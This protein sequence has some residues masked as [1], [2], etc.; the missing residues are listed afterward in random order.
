MV[1]LVIHQN[2]IDTFKFESQTPIF[3]DPYCPMVLQVAFQRMKSPVGQVHLGRFLS[4]VQFCQ[5]KAQSH[6][7]LGLYA[8]L[9]ASVEKLLQPFVAE[10]FYHFL[11]IALLYEE[12]AMTFLKFFLSYTLVHYAQTRWHRHKVDASLFQHQPSIFVR[13]MCSKLG[14]RQI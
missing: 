7:M 1:V 12:S 4:S 6:R 2:G 13:H 5:L 8:S 3:I 9:R 14:G 10:G 11:S